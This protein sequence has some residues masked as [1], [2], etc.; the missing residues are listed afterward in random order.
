[1]T[2]EWLSFIS[3]IVIGI[4][5]LIGVLYAN[6]ST[7]KKTDAIHEMQLKQM[8]EKHEMQLNEI[9]GDIK[10][11]EE[12]QDRHNEVIERTF[13]LEKTQEAQSRDIKTLYNNVDDM[14][15]NIKDIHSDIDNIN[16]SVTTIRENEIR[17]ETKV[18]N[19]N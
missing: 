17:L 3:S 10:R 12:K 19:N 14:K 2:G 7:R 4:L 8:G 5:T 13:K 18:K 16:R 11:L 6:N 15:G 1:M 9:K